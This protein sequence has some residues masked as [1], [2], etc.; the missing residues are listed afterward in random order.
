LH[1]RELRGFHHGDTEGTES[2]ENCL[3]G[4]VVLAFLASWQCKLFLML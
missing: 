1:R 4:R 3:T 2:T